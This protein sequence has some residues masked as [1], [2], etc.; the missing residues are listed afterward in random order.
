MDMAKK[1]D[2]VNDDVKKAKDATSTDARAVVKAASKALGH[3]SLQEDLFRVGGKAE[4]DWDQTIHEVDDLDTDFTDEDMVNKI[5]QQF[6]DVDVRVMQVGPGGVLTD[7][8]DKVNPK[9]LRPDQIAGLHTADGRSL[10]GRNPQGRAAALRFLQ[11]IMN[12]GRLSSEPKTT[13]ANS[14]RRMEAALAEG[15]KILEHWKK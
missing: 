13:T 6:G 8:S 7:V 15:D 12:S 10:L 9:D 3:R 2:D 5:R 11:D 1:K 14:I 4:E